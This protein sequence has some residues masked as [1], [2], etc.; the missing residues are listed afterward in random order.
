[1]FYEEMAELL[2]VVFIFQAEDGIRDVAV[3]GVQ[4]CALPIWG[5][6]GVT[7]TP[8]PGWK[9]ARMNVLSV[10]P[11]A[12]PPARMLPSGWIRTASKPTA[13]LGVTIPFTDRKSVV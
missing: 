8:P 10:P 6:T 4:T 2:S 13:A 5:T 7:R 11:S 3:T 12:V 1:M 9:R